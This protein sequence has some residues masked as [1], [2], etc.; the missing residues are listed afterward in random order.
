MYEDQP[1]FCADEKCRA[2]FFGSHP[3]SRSVLGTEKSI[4]DLPVEAMRDYFARRYSPGNIVLAAVGKVDF[5]ELIKTAE[6]RCGCWKPM[7]AGRAATRPV[8]HES[9]LVECKESA[10]QE[11]V[12]QLSPGPAAEDD[13]RHAAKLLAVILGDDSGSRLYWE[14]VDTGLA[15]QASLSH[16]EYQTAGMMATYMSCDPEQVESNLQIL[17]DIYFRAEADGVTEVELAQA[18]SKIRSHLVLSSERPRGRLFPVGGDWVYRREYC[19]IEQDMQTFADITLADINAILKKYS[20][21]KTT[22]LTIGPLKNV[23]EPK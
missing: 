19:T 21:T 1:P 23:K 14:L 17:H 3:L 2:A 4:A 22:T 15:E 16:G 7:D 9:F 12:L 20:L 10:S 5:D 8:L 6:K 18:K 13:E 11:Y